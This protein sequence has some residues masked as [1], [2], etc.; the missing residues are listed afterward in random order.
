MTDEVELKL[1]LPE[2]AQPLLLRHPLLNEATA[3]HRDQLLNIYYD[4]PGQALNA[5]H[6]AQRAAD[7]GHR[8]ADPAPAPDLPTPDPGAA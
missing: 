7:P 1:A 3:R 2:A 8:H 6:A 5:F 4:T